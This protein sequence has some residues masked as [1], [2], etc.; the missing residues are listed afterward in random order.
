MSKFLF[1]ESIPDCKSVRVWVKTMEN[2]AWDLEDSLFI[3][4]EATVLLLLP[5]SIKS[6]THKS[7]NLTNFSMEKLCVKSN[8]LFS[9]EVIVLSKVEVF[10]EGHKIRQNLHLLVLTI[11][12]NIK[13]K[14]EISSNFVAFSKYLNFIQITNLKKAMFCLYIQNY[15]EICSFVF[16]AFW[17]YLLFS[18]DN[19]SSLEQTKNSWNCWAC[20]DSLA[21]DHSQL[22]EAVHI[23]TEN[24]MFANLEAMFVWCGGHGIQQVVHFLVVNFH[25]GH[26]NF[27]LLQ[28]K[29]PY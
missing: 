24:V 3:L 19:N 17:T 12:S 11:L 23:W 2:T 20:L 27:S 15:G 26:F 4:V 28:Y 10:W 16:E 13:I 18:I 6:W 1:I 14:M 7:N 21:R 5:S 29:N 9:K 22:R 25:V 8:Y